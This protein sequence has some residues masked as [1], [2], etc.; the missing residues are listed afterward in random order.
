MNTDPEIAATFRLKSRIIKGS[1][2]VIWKGISMRY[3]KDI[4]VFVIGLLAALYLINPTFGVFELIPDNLPLVG[5]ID[6]AT[7]TGLLLAAVRYFGID[8][9]QAFKRRD[10]ETVV[11]PK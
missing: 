5:N 9:T 8:V 7:A 2:T 10:D 1:I 4:L 3:M 6:E 11:T